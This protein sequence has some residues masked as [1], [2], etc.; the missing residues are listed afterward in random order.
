MSLMTL[1]GHASNLIRQVW[2]ELSDIAWGSVGAALFH[3]SH[4]PIFGLAQACSYENGRNA[5]VQVE[6]DE[7][8]YGLSLEQRNS[9]L[10]YSIGQ[11]SRMA[12]SGCLE[13]N[14]TSLN[15]RQCKVI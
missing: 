9:L 8:S 5:N 14:F 10:L 7:A 12:K 3:I 13:I 4:P 11:S 2:R 15:G 6:T 1:A